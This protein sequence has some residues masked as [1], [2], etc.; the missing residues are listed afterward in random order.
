MSS[1][2]LC[3]RGDVRWRQVRKGDR[4]APWDA[5]AALAD[6][7]QAMFSRSETAAADAHRALGL[8]LNERAPFGLIDFF[9]DALEREHDRSNSELRGDT[10]ASVP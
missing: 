10:G 6:Y 8:F 3:A 9:I 1:W 2:P 5:E 7:E 4:C